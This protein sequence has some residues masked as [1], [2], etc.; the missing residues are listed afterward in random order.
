MSVVFS[1][2]IDFWR[3]SSETV[4]AA[5]GPMFSLWGEGKGRTWAGV[6]PVEFILIK[7]VE[8]R[9]ILIPMVLELISFFL[10]W[11]RWMH[12]PGEDFER[13]VSSLLT[14]SIRFV[15]DD[16]STRGGCRKSSF[17]YSIFQRIHSLFV[18]MLIYVTFWVQDV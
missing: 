17:Q 9:I 13:F 2:W 15:R 14:R 7:S 6:I 8:F 11:L 18:M 4:S 3:V 12:P 1:V 5:Y 16:A 10:Y